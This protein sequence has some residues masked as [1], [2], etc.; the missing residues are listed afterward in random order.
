MA[1]IKLYVG[2]LPWSA[3]SDDLGQKFSEAGTVVS[4]QVV[5]DRYSGRSRGFAFVEMETQEMADKAIEMFNGK[6]L[7]GREIVVNIARPREEG[8]ETGGQSMTPPP[9]DDQTDQPVVDDPVVADPVKEEVEVE[10]PAV[11]EEEKPAK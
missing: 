5:T 2:N 3:T 4:A 11:E 7:D 10:L 6:D 1:P 9:A 8:A